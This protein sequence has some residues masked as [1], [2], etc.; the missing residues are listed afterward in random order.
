MKQIQ[1]R[2]LLQ[3]L[4]GFALGRV[5]LFGMNPAGLA[6]FAAGFAE[7]GAVF[8]VAVTVLLGMSTVFP[9]EITAVYAAAMLSLWLA[10]DLLGR[11]EIELRM[12]H[13]AILLGIATMMMSGLRYAMMPQGT[14]ALVRILLEAVLIIAGT[15][16]LH[17]GVCYLL[18]SKRGIMPDGE[19]LVSLIILGGL[20][21]VGLPRVMI[22]DLSLLEIG[23]YFMIL[24]LGYCYGTGAGA[25]TGAV[26]G[27]ILVWGGQGSNMIGVAALLGICAG[28]LRKQGKAWMMSVFWIMAVSLHYMVSGVLTDMGSWKALGIDSIIFLCIPGSYLERIKYYSGE[29]RKEEQGHLQRLMKHKLQDFSESFRQLSRALA[30]QSDKHFQMSRHEMREL[31]QQMSEQVCER[32]ENREN[33]M[34]QLELSRSEIFGTLALA[35]EQGGIIP[36]QMPAPFLRE[37]I[38]LERFISET[39]QNL[40]MAKV[41]M[42]V[43]NKMSENRQ[44]MAGQMEEVGKLV[45]NLADQIEEV[46]DIPADAENRIFRKLQYKRVLASGIMIYEKHDGRLEIHMRARTARGRLVTAKEAAG[47]L[48]E[49]LQKPIRPAEDSRQI[50]GRDMSY[51]VFEE[52]TPLYTVTG[53]A[54]LPKDGEEISGDVFSC[55]ALPSGETLIALSDGM[56]SGQEAF[57]ESRTVIELLEQMSEAGFSHMSAI[58]LINSIYLSCEEAEHYATADIVILNLY[59]GTCQ[60]IKNGATATYLCRKDQVHRIE[61]QALPIGVVREAPSFTGNAEIYPG[62][63]VI[64]MTDGVSD[65]FAQQENGLEEYLENCGARQPGEVADCILEEAVRRC[66]GQ[67][68]DDMSVIVTGVWER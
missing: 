26:G 18:H 32:C 64:M 51:F 5:E 11:R 12:G 37:C 27:S 9:A 13:A 49:V 1:K 43:Q 30:E 47:V 31:M 66:K 41:M 42:G 60:F 20:G 53:V 35:E 14:W 8:P 7:G 22:A 59:Q 36:E 46:G 10:A 4:L 44:V 38:H 17:D 55:L 48:R 16:V 21:I 24:I 33:C 63:Y 58:K 34:G 65:C 56:G 6:Y 61:G 40:H 25:V 68:Q 28:M 54:R 2:M 67:V 62:D 29:Q 50:I 45:E 15:R 3:V 52:D 23:I 39:N 57:E 19:E